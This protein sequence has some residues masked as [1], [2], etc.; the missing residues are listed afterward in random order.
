MAKF[1]LTTNSPSPVLPGNE[2]DLAH[3]NIVNMYLSYQVCK[4]HDIVFFGNQS[5][6]AESHNTLALDI[7][8]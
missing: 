6:N 3:E 2:Q 1:Y 8:A 7:S 5:P 4:V